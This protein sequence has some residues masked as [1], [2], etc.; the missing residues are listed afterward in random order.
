[1]APLWNRRDVMAALAAAGAATVTGARGSLAADEP[2]EVTTIRLVKIPSIC[3]A[4][5]YVVEELLRAE[6]FTEVRYVAMPAALQ[7]RA[8]ARGEVDFSLHFVGPSIIAIDA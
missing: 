6:G 8:I 1:M 3:V 7:H 5:Q 4:P 2:P